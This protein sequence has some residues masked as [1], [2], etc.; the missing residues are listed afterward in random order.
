MSN[1]LAIAAVTYM[2]KDLLNDGLTN[3]NVSDTTGGLVKV[4][5]LPPD[6]V[7]DATDKSSGLNLFMYL[8]TPNQG[9]RNTD[10]PSRDRNGMRTGNPP[11]ALDLHY[12]LTAYATEEFHSDI[13]LGYGMLLLHEHPVLTRGAIRASLDA[14]SAPGT[15][16]P[17]K[18]K[19]LA[20]S[21]LAEQIEQIRI[22]QQPMGVDEWSRIWPAL[23]SKY[24]PTAAYQVS[25]VLM[26][27]A[28]AARTPLPVLRR[29][30]PE[31]IP[32]GGEGF[33]VTPSLSQPV[34]PTPTFTAVG[35]PDSQQSVRL[36][37]TITIDGF[38][39][40]G[41]DV[42]VV[43]EAK[44]EKRQVVPQTISPR[45]LTVLLPET[46]PDQWVAG[47]HA[48]SAL[49]R[50][51]GKDFHQGTNQ[52][53]LSL[54]P[55][56]TQPPVAAATANLDQSDL[57]DVKVSIKCAPHAGPG[58]RVSLLLN[59]LEA[60]AEPFPAATDSLQFRFRALP[61]GDYLCRLRVDG[62][63]SHFIDYS[64]KPPGFLTEARMT[65]P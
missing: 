42:I 5:A 6:V 8:A 63:D 57:L 2:L 59:D 30:R 22:T 19:A 41:D 7:L 21:G 39:L 16:L 15:G 18:L 26:E 37:E 55:K 56:I 50:R 51:P 20:G 12:F 47:L 43:F 27:S 24:R 58:Q 36:G 45:Q 62:I 46:A 44:G 32:G 31:E 40:D 23:Q 54:A 61:P 64:V 38:N 60:L 1:A 29:G 49:V 14:A 3:H 13:L 28:L 53:A 48:V 17:D 10:L 35:Y 33:S 4:T 25:V 52:L 9:W 11:L 34:P 65:I